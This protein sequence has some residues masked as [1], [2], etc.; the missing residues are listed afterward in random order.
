MDFCYLI[1]LHQTLLPCSGGTAIPSLTCPSPSVASH[2]PKKISPNIH[3]HMLHNAG[4]LQ[5]LGSSKGG[6]RFHFTNQIEHTYIKSTTFRPG[7]K[8]CPYQAKR[9]LADSWPEG[10]S[11]QDKT[12]EHTQHTLEAFLEAL[13]SGEQEALHVGYYWISSS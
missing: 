13:G 1:C 9:S 3:S 8:H 10:Q 2:L 12:A 7:A 4:D 6:N 5:S 11:E